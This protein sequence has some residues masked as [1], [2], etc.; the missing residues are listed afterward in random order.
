MSQFA[1]TI[2]SCGVL[3]LMFGSFANVLVH[4]LPRGESIVFPGSRCP[5][6]GR[7]IQWRDNIPVLSWLLLRG[8]CRHCSA[9]IHWRYPLLEAGLAVLWAFLAWHSGPGEHLAMALILSFLLWTLTWID[10][11][12]GLLPNA[13]TFPGIGIGLAFAYADGRFADAAIGAAAGYAV[14]WSVA[15]LYRLAMHR[16]G[17]GQGDF[18]LLAMLGAFFGWQALPFIIF[19]SSFSG[20]VIGGLML[21]FSGRSLRVEL[22][23]G[24]YL[25]AAG[26]LWLVWR[27]AL[28]AAFA[29][30]FGRSW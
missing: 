25:A 7:A 14:F 1:L 27:D 6:C 24:P 4:R 9:R 12:T 5:A 28:L 11:E 8:R 26:M 19:L 17:M 23:F 2:V 18:K 15:A 16:E 30:L 22:P 10:V 20:A 3:G 21:L 13:L 29:G